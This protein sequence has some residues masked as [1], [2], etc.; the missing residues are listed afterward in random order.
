MTGADRRAGRSPSRGLVMVL[1]LQLERSART[2]HRARRRSARAAARRR[3]TCTAAWPATGP[4][5][6]PRRW[7]PRPERGQQRREAR[8]D[9]ARPPARSTAGAA[10]SGPQSRKSRFRASSAT[11]RIAASHSVRERACSKSFRTSSMI[12]SNWS[13]TRG[14]LPPAAGPVV[15]AADSARSSGGRPAEWSRNRRPPRQTGPHGPRQACPRRGRGRTGQVGDQDAEEAAA[16]RLDHLDRPDA[17]AE[18]VQLLLQRSGNCS[19]SLART[20]LIASSCQT[21]GGLVLAADS[22]AAFAREF[23]CSPSAAAQV[24]EHSEDV[25]R[26]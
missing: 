14:C 5:T 4:A 10:D 16:A 13:P 15:R 19:R 7:R 12:P 2:V 18:L 9:R 22:L 6:A 21:A 1:R 3:R 17:L 8:N 25:Y 24:P 11:W 26:S 23:E 20:R